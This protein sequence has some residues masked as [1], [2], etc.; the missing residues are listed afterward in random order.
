MNEDPMFENMVV[1]GIF[2]PRKDE[3]IRGGRK[4]LTS[5]IIFTPQRVAG[6]IWLKVY[7][8]DGLL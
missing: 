6:F 7:I 8:S 2:K 5:S 3:E 1:R 4:W